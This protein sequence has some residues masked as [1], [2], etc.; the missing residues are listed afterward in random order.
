MPH[1]SDSFPPPNETQHNAL[2]HHTGIGITQWLALGLLAFS[3]LAVVL[4]V[5]INLILGS[6]G[7]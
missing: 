7:G 3:L 1:S 5:V 2:P 6:P 4:A